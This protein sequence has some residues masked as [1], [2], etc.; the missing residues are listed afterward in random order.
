MMEKKMAPKN[1][2]TTETE[3]KKERKK[4][5][6]EKSELSICCWRG[7]KEEEE[8]KE[9]EEQE[10]RVMTTRLSGPNCHIVELRRRGRRS[11][12]TNWNCGC[13]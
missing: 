11:C 2:W 6:R 13:G 5:R 12:P 8:E 3:R 10:E 4:E 7:R 9:E 1:S